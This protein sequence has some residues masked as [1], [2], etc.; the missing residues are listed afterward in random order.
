VTL[1]VHA[2]QPLA[3]PL[4]C[5]EEHTQL[6]RTH[7]GPSRAVPSADPTLT[8][9]AALRQDP[10]GRPVISLD[11]GH[12][13]LTADGARQYAAL[14]LEL[15]DQ[16]AGGSAMTRERQAQVR[17]AGKAS[18]PALGVTVRLSDSVNVGATYRSGT[19]VGYGVVAPREFPVPVEIDAYAVLL[20]SLPDGVAAW[21]ADRCAEQLPEPLTPRPGNACDEAWANV[22]RDAAGGPR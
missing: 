9:G 20:V 1:T 16:L 14:L 13:T 15:A 5:V 2:T 17:N 7:W 3:C 6:D 21:S 8:A 10:D 4:W 18:L 11:V 19:V 12:D 22:A